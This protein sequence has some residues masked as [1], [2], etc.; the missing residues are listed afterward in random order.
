MIFDDLWL[1][2]S[3]QFVR[4]KFHVFYKCYH[5][6]DPKEINQGPPNAISKLND[7]NEGKQEEESL[8]EAKPMGNSAQFVDAIEVNG[9][10]KF[11]I[12]FT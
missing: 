1:K 8:D 7:Q 4:K 10:S 6:A 5:F 12:E 9:K 2:N 11:I 3:F